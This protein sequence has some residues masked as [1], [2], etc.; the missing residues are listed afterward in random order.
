MRTVQ[1]ATESF[2]IRSNHSNTQ[3]IKKYHWCFQ[4]SKLTSYDKLRT[5]FD[6]KIKQWR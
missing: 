6:G 1:V 4:I 5:W 3:I 2:S